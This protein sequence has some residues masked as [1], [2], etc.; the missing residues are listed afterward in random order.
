MLIKSMSVKD[1]SLIDVDGV[2]LRCSN[3]GEPTSNVD[4]VNERQ[5]LITDQRRWSQR[6]A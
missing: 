6:F 1:G 2:N 5:R 3:E 4:G